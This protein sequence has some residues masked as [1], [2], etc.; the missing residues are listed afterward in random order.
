MDGGKEEEGGE[1]PEPR[2]NWRVSTSCKGC[3]VKW[4]CGM[5]PTDSVG[6]EE[7]GYGFQKDCELVTTN[8]GTSTFS[9]EANENFPL[10]AQSQ[11]ILPVHIVRVELQ[12]NMFQHLNSPQVHRHVW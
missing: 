9:K 8:E 10:P 3:D 5:E 4:H 2:G 11:A 7:G 12:L 6:E 1:M